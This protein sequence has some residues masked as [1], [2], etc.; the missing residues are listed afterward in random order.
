MHAGTEQLIFGT[1]S[2]ARM[3]DAG[4]ILLS[5]QGLEGSLLVIV[6]LDDDHLP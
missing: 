6:I 5:Q 4:G 3:L 2:L 1:P